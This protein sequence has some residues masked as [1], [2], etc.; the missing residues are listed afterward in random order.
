M[1][2]STAFFDRMSLFNPEFDYM[3]GY[4]WTYDGSYLKN[5]VTGYTT[6]VIFKSTQGL[7]MSWG[8]IAIPETH[9]LYNIKLPMDLVN[10][11]DLDRRFA[12]VRHKTNLFFKEVLIDLCHEVL[13]ERN[14]SLNK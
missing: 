11:N 1:R 13:A 6:R 14:L 7:L 2:Y 8:A 9:Y 5:S 12:G 3:P 10:V 4:P